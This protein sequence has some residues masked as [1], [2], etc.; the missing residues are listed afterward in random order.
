[1][2]LLRHLRAMAEKKLAERSKGHSKGQT[3]GGRKG[4]KATGKE[5]E[6]GTVNMLFSGEEYLVRFCSVVVRFFVIRESNG[7]NFS[8][9]F[10]QTLIHTV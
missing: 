7:Y 8:S 4:E 1:M 10:I 9:V 3:S 2:P 6:K 5:K